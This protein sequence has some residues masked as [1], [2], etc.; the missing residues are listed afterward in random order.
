M[1]QNGSSLLDSL[2]LIIFLMFL[3]QNPELLSIN[4]NC[5]LYNNVQEVDKS[6][7]QKKKLQKKNNNKKEKLKKHTFW[8]QLYIYARKVNYVKIKIMASEPGS[9]VTGYLVKLHND[10]ITLVNE[11]EKINIPINKI[12]TLK[13][14]NCNK[15]IGKNKKQPES[16][17]ENNNFDNNNQTNI[18]KYQQLQ[19]PFYNLMAL[20]N[21]D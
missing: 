4:Q 19:L 14:E 2:N 3:K 6:F 17:K 10:F 18:K 11:G 5:D 20:P 13:L 8:D 12:L 21:S 16:H 7:K 9:K 15:S 1:A